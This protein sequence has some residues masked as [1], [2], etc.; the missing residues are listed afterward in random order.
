MIKFRWK[1][2]ISDRRQNSGRK[3]SWYFESRELAVEDAVRTHTKKPV[4]KD[5]DTLNWIWGQMENL[6]WDITTDERL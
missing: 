2:P 3:E 5:K 6:G 4:S 1:S